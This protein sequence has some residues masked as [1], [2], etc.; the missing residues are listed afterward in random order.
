MSIHHGPCNQIQGNG[1]LIVCDCYS[2]EELRGD[3]RSD[4]E[5]LKE[6][7]I[8]AGYLTCQNGIQIHQQGC[9]IIGYMYMMTTSK[10]RQ[11]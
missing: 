11:I 1:G 6:R 7:K 2:N 9:H 4:N 3:E 8:N 10:R 5:E